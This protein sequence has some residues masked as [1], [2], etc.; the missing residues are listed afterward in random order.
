MLNNFMRFAAEEAE[1]A[2]GIAALGLDLKAFI[3]QLVTFL[4]VFYILNK[5]VFGRIVKLL[6]KRREV[7]EQGVKLTNEMVAERDKLEKEVDKTMAK[8]R[9][10]ADEMLAKT[11]DQATQI[12]KDA[13]SSA[14]DKVDAMMTDAKRKIDDETA[15]AKKKLEKEMLDLVVEATEIVTNE[16]IDAQKDSELLNNALKGKV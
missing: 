3:I 5:F 7:I 11:H 10:E 1:P 12:I 15:K 2:S 4:F 16:K 14:Q 8:A 6:D 13:E 9:K